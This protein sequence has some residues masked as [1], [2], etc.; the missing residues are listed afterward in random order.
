MDDAVQEQGSASL[1]AG[2][3]AGPQAIERVLSPVADEV[4]SAHGRASGPH[5]GRRDCGAVAVGEPR[6][7]LALE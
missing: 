4:G 1:L 6:P 2:S 3:P 5:G 7:W